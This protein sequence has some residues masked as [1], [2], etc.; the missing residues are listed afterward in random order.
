MESKYITAIVAVIIIAAGLTG[1][2]Y[3]QASQAA[4]TNG[5]V[6][7]KVADAPN[8]SVSGVFI[9]FSDVSLHNNASG[10]T[11]YSVKSTTVNIL[12]LTATNASLLTNITLSAGTY[13]MIRLYITNVTV[14]MLGANITFSLKAP[15]AFINHPFKVSAHGNL[16]VVIEF[17]LT[18]D[19]NLTSN[20]FTPN[21]GVVVS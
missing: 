11:N 15:F 17:N 12:G 8:S 6:A 20:V 18:Q 19:L 10:W 1:L 21:V 9:T 2:V 4:T 16:N 3:Y 5:H 7:M 13:T 14:D